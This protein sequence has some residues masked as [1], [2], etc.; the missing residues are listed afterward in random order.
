VDWTED[1]ESL[2]ELPPLIQLWEK[3][4]VREITSKISKGKVKRVLE[5]GC[6]NG[7]WL[8]WF[9]REYGCEAYGVDNNTVE[10]RKRDINF[11]ASDAFKS[12][13]RQNVFDVVFS[14][15][16]I[17]HFKKRERFHYCRSKCQY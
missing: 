1:I 5:V 17:E 13:Y 14:K 4:L 2:V 15:G 3:E 10:F 8:R 12:P 9:C 6:S 11:M 7:R 16:F